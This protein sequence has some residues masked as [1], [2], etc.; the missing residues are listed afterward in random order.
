MKGLGHVVGKFVQSFIFLFRTNI[1]TY[2]TYITS[3]ILDY[4]P[5]HLKGGV[6]LQMFSLITNFSTY[7]TLYNIELKCS[8]LEHFLK[9]ILITRCNSSQL[10]QSSLSPGISMLI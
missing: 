7:C 9:V 1:S 2:L 6:E 5:S 10:S 8:S 4:I 3:Y